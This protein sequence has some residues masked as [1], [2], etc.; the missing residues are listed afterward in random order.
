MTPSA[1]QKGHCNSFFILAHLNVHTFVLVFNSF[2]MH[3]YIPTPQLEDYP[4]TL[5]T[6]IENHDKLNIGGVLNIFF[7]QS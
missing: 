3:L 2:T 6:G 1:V 4:L 7:Y 5:V